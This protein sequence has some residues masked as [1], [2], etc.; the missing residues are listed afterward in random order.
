MPA[1]PALPT[2]PITPD[3]QRWLDRAL[4]AVRFVRDPAFP[5]VALLAATMVAGF[6]VLFFTWAGVARTI[7]VALQVPHLVSGG[8]AALALIGLGAAL[9]DLQLGRRDAARE[10]RLTDQVIDE[11]AELMV[12]VPAL[13]ERV[14]GRTR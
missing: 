5:G 14:R 12:Q 1:Q 3:E 8:I 4:V 10:Q 7:F 11:V 13:R 9:L 6:V 2:D